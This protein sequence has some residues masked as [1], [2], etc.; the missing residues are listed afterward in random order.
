ML[1]TA[2]KF[3]LPKS[4]ENKNRRGSTKAEIKECNMAAVL[5]LLWS[6]TRFAQVAVL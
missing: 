3:A 4:L 1:T 6:R 5:A 2:R